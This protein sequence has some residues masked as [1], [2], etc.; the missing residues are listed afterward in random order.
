MVYSTVR[1][2]T[3]T[4]LVLVK[5]HILVIS[6]LHQLANSNECGSIRTWPDCW[7]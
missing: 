3:Y 2:C 5:Y 4:Y 1:T 7:I 6:G